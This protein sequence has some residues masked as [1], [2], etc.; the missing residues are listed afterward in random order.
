MKAKAQAQTLEEKKGDDLPQPEPESTKDAPSK[1]NRLTDTRELEEV[2]QGIEDSLIDVKEEGSTPGTPPLSKTVKVSEPEPEPELPKIPIQVE[3]KQ[4]LYAT[5][6]RSDSVPSPT[7]RLSTRALISDLEKKSKSPPPPTPA[8][9]SVSCVEPEKARGAFEQMAARP[10]IKKPDFDDP[11]LKKLKHMIV[12]GSRT[13]KGL[14][15][16]KSGE[17][18]GSP[19]RT[20]TPDDELVSIL[21]YPRL[22]HVFCYRYLILSP[23][24]DI[25]YCDGQVSSLRPN[26]DETYPFSVQHICYI[27]LVPGQLFVLCTVLYGTIH[28][29]YVYLCNG[30][31]LLCSM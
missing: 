13:R 1:A 16:D 5:F 19:S 4:P 12:R 27:Y 28:D 8:R 25:V 23:L 10:L 7:P 18:S 26:K 11:E 17:E 3:H 2:I 22:L 6:S 15:F 20:S 14:S 21:K 29:M 9:R 31:P 30:V 24:S